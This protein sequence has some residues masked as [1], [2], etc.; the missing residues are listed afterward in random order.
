MLLAGRK[1]VDEFTAACESEAQKVRDD[2][3]IT[4]YT[5]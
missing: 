4:K 3:S 1:S 2:D 5:R